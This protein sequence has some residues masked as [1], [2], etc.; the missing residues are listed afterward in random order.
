MFYIKLLSILYYYFQINL[1][2]SRITRFTVVILKMSLIMDAEINK[3]TGT[4]TIAILGTGDIMHWRCFSGIQLSRRSAK[5]SSRSDAPSDARVLIRALFYTNESFI[6]F[7][8][9]VCPLLF[10]FVNSVQFYV[11]KL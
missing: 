2:V 1:I 9:S 4:H 10:I 6:G 8:N 5:T 3:S 7:A 11:N